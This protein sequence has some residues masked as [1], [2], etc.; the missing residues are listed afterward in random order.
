MINMSKFVV[1]ALGGNAILQ[2]RQ[3]GTADTQY[4]NIY[5]TCEHIVKLIKSGYKSASNPW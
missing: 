4:Q 5:A 3:N 2:P 1:I